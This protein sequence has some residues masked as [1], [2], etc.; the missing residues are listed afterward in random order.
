[1]GYNRRSQALAGKPPAS[2]SCLLQCGAGADLAQYWVQAWALCID[3]GSLS[4]F[5]REIDSLCF[6]MLHNSEPRNGNSNS[7]LTIKRFGVPSG[8]ELGGLDQKGT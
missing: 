5:P 4:P 3:G 7:L 1:M 6:M 8:L 2:K